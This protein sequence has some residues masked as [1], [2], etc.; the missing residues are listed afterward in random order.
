MGPA[1]ESAGV[2]VYLRGLKAL[3]NQSYKALARRAGVGSS[4]LHRYCSGEQFPIDYRTVR[5]FA[6]ACGADADEL[7]CLERLW[8]ADPRNPATAAGRASPKTA[9]GSA[10]AGAADTTPPRG[11]REV[12]VVAAGIGGAVVLVATAIAM[13][14]RVRLRVEYRGRGRS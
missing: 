8:S 5:S 3:S 14:S 2:A 1:A 10:V 9:E 6:A 12:R 13:R 11:R 4:T 7:R